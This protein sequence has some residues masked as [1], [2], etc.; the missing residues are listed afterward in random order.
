MPRS[1]HGLDDE[2]DEW[3][4]AGSSTKENNEHDDEYEDEETHATVTIIEDF[5]PDTIIH[6]EPRTDTLVTPSSPTSQPEA[7]Q[8]Q[9]LTSK[10]ALH[11]STTK[12]KPKEK[13]I[14]Y[15]TKDARRREQKKQRARRKEKAELAGGKAARKSK[16]NGSKRKHGSKR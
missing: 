4:G 7:R 3:R 16:T 8:P 9:T 12:V 1:N 5:D 15:E 13:K 14:R 6:G 10:K 11:G 2:D